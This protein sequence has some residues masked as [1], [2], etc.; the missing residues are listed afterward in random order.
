MN[1]LPASQVGE[2]KMSMLGNS[3]RRGAWGSA[4]GVL[5]SHLIPLFM[6]LLAAE[7]VFQPVSSSL[8]QYLG[9][10]LQAVLFQ[11]GVFCLAGFLMGLESLIWEKECWSLL[12]QTMVHSGLSLCTLLPAFFVCGWIESAAAFL[13]WLGIFLAIYLFVW[14]ACYLA[15]LR[16]VR[17]L[18]RLL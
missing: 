7:G 15:G 3:I 6:S 16:T 10:E 13:L 9:N 14:C 11:S 4:I 5:A 1:Y 12:R 8:L 18:N 17:E 2:S